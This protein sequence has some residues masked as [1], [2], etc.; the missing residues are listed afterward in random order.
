MRGFHRV[1]CGLAEQLGKWQVTIE[2]DFPDK[3]DLLRRCWRRELGGASFVA[4]REQRRNR[5]KEI[6]KGVGCTN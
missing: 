4:T 1:L 5:R 2:V 6:R 3:R